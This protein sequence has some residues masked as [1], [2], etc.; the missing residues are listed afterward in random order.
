MA[1]NNKELQANSVA[2]DHWI[3]PLNPYKFFYDFSNFSILIFFIFIFYKYK[4]FE[5]F[6]LFLI[7][8]FMMI[9]PFIVNNFIINW[10]FFPDQSKYFDNTRAIRSAIFDVRELKSFL[11]AEKNKVFLSSFIYAIMPVS[12]IETYNSIGFINRFFIT[13]LFVFLIKGNHLTLSTKLVFLISPSLILY[14]SVSLRESLILVLMIFSLYNL[15][16]KNHTLSFISI[17]LLFFLKIQNLIIVLITY[18]AFY[19]L[20]EFKK[21]S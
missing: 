18:L 5:I 6:P 17:V 1:Y 21:K 9:T 7:S 12:N 2:F 15:L 20:K 8:F 10:Q 13:I 19:F 4:K 14:S 11:V 3:E 16:Y